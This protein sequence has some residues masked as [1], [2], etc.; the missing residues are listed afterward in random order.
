VSDPLLRS[1]PAQTLDR[2]PRNAIGGRAARVV[3]LVSITLLGGCGVKPAADVNLPSIRMNPGPG[4]LRRA[5]FEVTGLPAESLEYLSKTGEKDP[6][7]RSRFLV[8]P[9]DGDDLLATG[10][11]SPPMAGN[12]SAEASVLRFR[13]KF[14]L[15]F[16]RRYL[17]VFDPKGLPGLPGDSGLISA[18]FMLPKPKVSSIPHVPKAEPTSES[19]PIR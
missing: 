17:A 2:P 9:D 6:S 14:P 19:A 12:W 1:E 15:Q 13:P 7:N 10:G 18:V 3:L 8:R 4:D 11:D 16:G 5:T